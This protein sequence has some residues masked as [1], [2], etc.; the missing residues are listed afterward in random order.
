MGNFYVNHAVVSDAASKIAECLRAKRRTA[1]V[2]RSIGSITLF[3]DEDS[4]SQQDDAIREAGAVVSA[5]L[6]CA[7]LAVLNHDDDILCYWL[8]DDGA[9]VD[10]Y[11][12]FPG[13]FSDGE[14]APTG[15]D[16]GKLCAAFEVPESVAEL[17]QIL[18]SEEY[19]F[20]LDRHEALA[21]LLRIPWQYACTGYRYTVAGQ[22][23]E[24][25]SAAD[26]TR[27]E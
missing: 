10:E 27:V 17:E 16:A 14:S 7:V 8:F 4:D 9:V 13:Y 25:L 23:A 26:F 24:G 19:A 18:R 11:N 1:F 22:Y 2:G 20:A 3:F 5:E 6:K 12:S 15:G 21:K